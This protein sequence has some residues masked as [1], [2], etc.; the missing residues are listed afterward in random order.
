MSCFWVFSQYTHKPSSKCVYNW[1]IECSML[2]QQKALHNHF[3]LG[4]R[5]YIYKLKKIRV[6]QNLVGKERKGWVAY[7]NN[8]LQLLC[9]LTVNSLRY[10]SQKNSLLPYFHTQSEEQNF[11]SNLQ[12]FRRCLYLNYG[13]H[14]LQYVHKGTAENPFKCGG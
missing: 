11:N 4:N 3:K 1:Q 13:V 6:T 14:R 10:I 5:K 2:Y 7:Q 8:I 12:W 9:I